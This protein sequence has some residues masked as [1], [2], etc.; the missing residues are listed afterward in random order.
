LSLLNYT[1]KRL[2]TFLQEIRHLSTSEFP[3]P[4]SRVAL[5]LLERMFDYQ[6]TRLS[7]LDEESNIQVINE[8]CGDVVRLIVIYLPVLG[9]ILRSTNVRNAFEVYRPSL[10]LAGDI[11]EPLTPFKERKTRLI[12]SSEWDYSPY[13]YRELPLLPGFALIGLPAPESSNPL[14]V[15]LSGHELGHVIWAK[16]KIDS[17]FA[18]KIREKIIENIRTQWVEYKEIFQSPALTPDKIE[19]RLDEYPNWAIADTWALKQAEE[20]FCDFIGLCIFDTSFL[21]A[22]AYLI[23]PNLLRQRSVYYPKMKSRVTNLLQAAKIY[24]VS[25]PPDYVA[26]FEDDITP[27]RT[28]AD[29]FRLSL[30]DSGLQ[31]VVND[32]IIAAKGV[33]DSS[34]L[35]KSPNEEQLRIYKRLKAVVPAENCGTL[36]DILN[37]AWKLHGEDDRWKD[38]PHLHKKRDSILKNVVL[39]NIEVFEIEQI[40]GE[41]E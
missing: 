15:P 41:P 9:F 23:S 14:L 22:F 10:R 20:S 26:L 24:N 8:K 29:E 5:D 37:A 12:L 30:A 21:H 3:Y 17:V 6:L 16:N 39:K 11:I 27:P 13:V 34:A 1:E 19:E 36:P 33:I 35:K 25:T 2:R 4:D 32:L 38:I 31:G 40:M 28:K 18:P 7:E